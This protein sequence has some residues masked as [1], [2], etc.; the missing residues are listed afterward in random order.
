MALFGSTP[1]TA[2]PAEAPAPTKPEK[3]VRAGAAD[4]PSGSSD[5]SVDASSA[6]SLN[7]KTIHARI[8]VD[9]FGGDDVEIYACSIAHHGLLRD[10][11]KLCELQLLSIVCDGQ[12]FAHQIQIVLA[13]EFRK[14]KVGDIYTLHI[15]F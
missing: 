12:N 11:I 13:L 1:P 4:S 15:Y 5:T 7:R 8:W 6:V 10:R 3:N 9:R 14:S 2:A